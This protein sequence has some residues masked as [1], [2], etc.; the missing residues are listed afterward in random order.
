MV[1]KDYFTDGLPVIR[2][3]QNFIMMKSGGHP[4]NPVTNFSV[5]SGETLDIHYVPP[6]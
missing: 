4:S 1:P 2:G 6:I 3:T 5:T